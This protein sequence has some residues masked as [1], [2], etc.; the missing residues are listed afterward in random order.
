MPEQPAQ[1]SLRPVDAANWRDVAR[2]TVTADQAR[3]VTTPTYYLAMCTYGDVWHPL[4][5][6]LEERVVGFLMWG[7]DDADD[8]CWLGGI[9]VD[10]SVQG[11]GL[12]RA[13][14]RE[15]LDVLAAR[16][17]RTEFALSYQPE[18]LVARRL[19]A[20]L[21]FVETG[22]EEDGELVARLSMT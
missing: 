21:G 19:Y 22:E 18:N 1:V 3:F 14:V 12:G 7:I 8:S 16:T 17:G 4:A 20:G 11:R 6:F 13:M 5:A 15:A 9:L 2:L 10:A